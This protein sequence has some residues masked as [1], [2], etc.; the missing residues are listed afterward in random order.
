MGS[1]REV[2]FGLD[3]MQNPKVLSEKDSLKQ[4]MYN[5]FVSRP[6]TYPSQ[7]NLGINIRDYLYRFEDDIDTEGLKAKIFMNCVDLFKI[8][9]KDDI[10]ITT[11]NYKGV[12]MLLIA[13]PFMLE[14]KQSLLLSFGLNGDNNILY[15]FKVEAMKLDASQ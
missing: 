6:G 13:I 15:G 9:N 10:V 12:G 8:I 14:S 5:I 4:I 2:G 3:D 7:P 11:V 1:I